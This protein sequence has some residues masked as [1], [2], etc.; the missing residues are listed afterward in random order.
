MG[1][2]PADLVLT[3]AIHMQTN[4][5]S[6]KSSTTL[7]TIKYR[8]NIIESVDDDDEIEWMDDPFEY[9]P[10]PAITG[11]SIIDLI[12]INGLPEDTSSVR[13]K[14]RHLRYSRSSGIS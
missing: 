2:S 5:Y 9:K 4:L 14:L 6:L 8:S 1:V 3:N 12:K 10:Q 11:S 7:A 13:R